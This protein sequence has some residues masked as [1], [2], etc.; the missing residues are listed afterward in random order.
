MLSSCRT[1][2]RRFFASLSRW[3]SPSAIGSWIGEEVRS[4]G[5]EGTL[6]LAAGGFNELELQGGVFLCNDSIGA[7]LA[8]RG[9]ALHD[10]QGTYRD[11]LP[12]QAVLSLTDPRFFAEQGRRTQPFHEIDDR[13]GLAG[14][15]TL[16][17]AR[18]WWGTCSWEIIPASGTTP[19]CVE[20]STGLWWGP[21]AMSRTTRCSTSPTIIHA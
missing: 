2:P 13:P 21:S 1:V 12:L 17:A 14:A 16:R 15:S 7:L 4:T 20:T 8:W 18:S 3:P 9:F 19:C 5:V 10:R 6:V 11:E